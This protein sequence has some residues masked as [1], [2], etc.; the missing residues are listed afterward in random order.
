[1]TWIVEV[2]SSIL[3]GGPKIIQIKDY[4]CA[5]ALHQVRLNFYSWFL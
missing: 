3:L 2:S 1:M 4:H 5:V